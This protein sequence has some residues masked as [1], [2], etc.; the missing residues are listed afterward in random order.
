MAITE[1]IVEAETEVERLV[2]AKNSKHARAID[3]ANLVDAVE[4][5]RQLQAE[6]QNTI[7]HA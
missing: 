3:A 4:K 5:L 2:A 7:R 6:A 1:K